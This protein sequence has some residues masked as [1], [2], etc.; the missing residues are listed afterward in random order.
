MRIR[1]FSKKQLVNK[2]VAGFHNNRLDGVTDLLLRAKDASVLDI[3]MNRGMVSLE[4]AGNGASVCH[5]CDN[6]EAGVKT[7]KEVFSDIPE[8]NS[9]FEVVDLTK[10]PSALIEAFGSDYRKYDII[11][12]LA[13]DHELQRIMP[14]EEINTLVEHLAS[15]TKRYFTYRGRTGDV[16][17]PIMVKAGL[18]RVHYSEISEFHFGAPAIIWERR[19]S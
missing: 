4:F 14:Q 11:L 13:L 18:T 2:R 10:G 8:V 15:R 17:E 1:F 12:F 5:G 7:A 6:Y 3:G 9:R 16:Y 19:K